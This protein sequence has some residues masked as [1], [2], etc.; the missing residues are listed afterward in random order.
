MKLPAPKATEPEVIEPQAP[1]VS[2]QA[3]TYEQL[4]DELLG[5][6]VVGI[7]SLLLSHN[8]VNV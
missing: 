3:S 1:V 7:T 6:Y 8:G 4:G 5:E 2:E